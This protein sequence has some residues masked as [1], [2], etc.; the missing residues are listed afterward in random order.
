MTVSTQGG[1]A[2]LEQLGMTADEVE[3]WEVLGAVAGRMLNLLE[4]HPTERHEVVHDFH[5][6]Q[7]RLLARP[8]LRTA[9]WPMSAAPPE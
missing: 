6:L 5:R 7:L 9:G 2:R 4:L 1:S 3:L 8:G